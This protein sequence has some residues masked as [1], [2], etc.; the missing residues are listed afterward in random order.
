MRTRIC[1]SMSMRRI[2]PALGV[3]KAAVVVPIPHRL[4]NQK[5]SDDSCHHQDISHRTTR[6]GPRERT[7]TLVDLE[8]RRSNRHH[9][10]HC[11]AEP[12]NH[13]KRQQASAGKPPP[14]TFDI[15]LLDAVRTEARWLR[16]SRKRHT[17][18]AARNSQ[19]VILSTAVRTLFHVWCR[20]NAA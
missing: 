12:A 18:L 16:C 17:A 4:R 20:V 6:T 8:C 1:V 15:L 19:I 10:S 14:C 9:D 7:D 3:P 2:L 11:Q 5:T 13:H